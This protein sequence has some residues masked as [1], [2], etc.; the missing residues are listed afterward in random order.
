MEN[1]SKALIIAGAILISILLITVGIM[2]ISSTDGITDEMGSSMSE[3]EI[4]SFNS[5]FTGYEADKQKASQ[6]KA[7]LD[8][9]SATNTSNEATS[10]S[11]AKFVSI[12]FKVGNN[13][14]ITDVDTARQSVKTTKTYKVKCTKDTNTGLVN[15]ITI[16]EN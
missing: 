8:K 14:P 5:K 16:T 3:M 13:T 7:L 15:L 4:Q 1:A 12:S 2:V 10:S 9:V 6:V 11:D